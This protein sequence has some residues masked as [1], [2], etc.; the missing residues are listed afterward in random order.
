MEHHTGTWFE[1][2]SRLHAEGRPCAV[3]VVTEVAGSTPRETGARLIVA[4][5]ELVWGTIGGG[6]LE[7]LAIEHAG[8]LLAQGGR[9]TDTVDYPLS[10]KAGQCCGGKVTLFYET[11]PWTA[12]QVVVF[13]A[14]HVAQALAALQPYL[15][16]DV[17]LIDPRE[18]DEIRPRIPV[19]KPWRLL[20]VDAPEEEIDE[21]PESALVLIMT[22]DHAL[23]QRVLE[24]ALRRG[25]FPYVGLIGSGR[26]WARF[27]AR[28]AERGITEGQLA[29]VTCPIGSTKTT[30]EPLTIA[31]SVAN[32]LLEVMGELERAAAEG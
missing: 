32:E 9:R 18:E 7:H 14:G 31:I 22:H 3:V 10:E 28:L 23:D 12:R 11:Y 16:S 1:T 13:G 25:C 20:C 5:G 21:L 15:Q 8:A 29:T 26:K 17:L 30:K 27:R 4:G 6:K 2:L 24:R 19:S